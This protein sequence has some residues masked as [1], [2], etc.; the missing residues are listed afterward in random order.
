MQKIFY[1]ICLLLITSFAYTQTTAI[2]QDGRKVLLYDNNTWKYE[3][4]MHFATLTLILKNEVIIIL[5]K[6]RVISFGNIK[7]G[8]V[9][10]YGNKVT[11]VGN[12]HANYYGDNVTQIGTYQISYY[13]NKISQI[14]NLSLS[15]YGEKITGLGNYSIGYYGDK[16]T[17][18]SGSMQD[19]TLSGF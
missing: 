8:A 1:T 19:C 7:G 18:I 12:I 16:I 3:E 14:W 10:Y 13:G 17:S 6:G 15:Y 11:Q 4:S 9:S 5:Q 2:T